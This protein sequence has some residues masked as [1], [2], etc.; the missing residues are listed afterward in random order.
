MQQT[1]V[2]DNVLDFTGVCK[3]PKPNVAFDTLLVSN[4]IRI[5]SIFT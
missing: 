2:S 3:D 4:K 5:P 1:L